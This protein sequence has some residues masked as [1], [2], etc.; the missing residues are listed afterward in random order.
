MTDDERLEWLAKNQPEIQQMLRDRGR[1]QWL[2][3]VSKSVALWVAAI[4]AAWAILRA[5]LADFI[6]AGE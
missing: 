3:S 5:G 1:W 6:G 2:G 4:G